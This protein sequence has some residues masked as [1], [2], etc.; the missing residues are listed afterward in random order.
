MTARRAGGKPQRVRQ[1]HV[2]W[3]AERLSERDRAIVASVHRLRCL[4][5]IQL[6]RL[7][8]LD[9]S[10]ST[11]SRIRRR[12]LARLVAWRVLTTFER[13]IGG[14]RAGSAG[15]AFAL[16]SAG[17]QLATRESGAG[18]RRPRQPSVTLLSHTLA[19]AE[20]YVRLV[21]LS[22]ADGFTVAAFATEPDCW[23]PLP[24][25]GWLKPDA[26]LKLSTE[27]VSDHWWIE[28]DK[29]TEHLP[30][31]RRKVLAYLDFG[32]AGG[33]GPGGVLPR[34]LF[35]VPNE[36]RRQAVAQLIDKLPEPA[37]KFAY[38]ANE[39]QAPDWLLARLRE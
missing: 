39:Q 24:F 2:E 17:Q 20:L 18:V 29:G 3:V 19:V 16:D 30:V 37:A 35:T 33:L 27:A 22:R 28:A 12:V 38:V 7:H 1:A 10:F 36:A 25:G 11:R 6:E 26:Y 14:V 15:L 4:T 31:L 32:H 21:E 8:F 34:V 23:R 13:R 9:L 5:G